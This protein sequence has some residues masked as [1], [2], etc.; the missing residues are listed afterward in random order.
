MK[1]FFRNN[2]SFI[3]GII[4]IALICILLAAMGKWHAHVPVL[5]GMLFTI[6]LDITGL[7]IGV[8]GIKSGNKIDSIAGIVLC[9]ICLLLSPWILFTWLYWVMVL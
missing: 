6:I 9:S 5:F 2:I 7:I 3:L 4:S 1:I 8:K